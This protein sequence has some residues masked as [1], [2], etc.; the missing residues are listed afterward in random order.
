MSYDRHIQ[1]G[2]DALGNTLITGDGNIVIQ[3]VTQTR[4]GVGLE[5]TPIP[6]PMVENP[7]QGL[8]A[9]TESDAHRFFGREQLTQK[10]WG[11]FRGLHEP[12]PG[13][14]S[15]LRL[16]PI[17]GPSG[18][19]KSSLARAGLIPELARRPLLGLRS[20]RVAVVMPG[21][22][23]LEALASMLARIAINDPVPVA[24]A[25]EFV[26]ELKRRNA[27]GEYD[28]LRRVAGLLPGITDSPLI[29]LI[30]QCEELYAL[31]EDTGERDVG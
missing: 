27:H 24:K 31:C 18:S 25:R 13:G 11:I 12:P 7:Y 1:I 2:G 10:L 4:H 21:A 14:P 9:F 26:A 20:V 22:H 3:I 30:D 16:L 8:S 15:P 6:S 29:V 19:G 17:L 23:P 28:G 5:R